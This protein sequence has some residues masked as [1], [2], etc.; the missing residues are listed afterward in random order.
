MYINVIAHNMSTQHKLLLNKFIIAY[1]KR[2]RQVKL[3][4]YNTCTF[5]KC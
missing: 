2:K 1:L 4:E 3:N 5:L